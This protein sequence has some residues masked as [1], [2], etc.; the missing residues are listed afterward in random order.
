M[1]GKVAAPKT[2]VV[3]TEPQR[4][5]ENINEHS[6]IVDDQGILQRFNPGYLNLDPKRRGAVIEQGKTI[7][8]PT[9]RNREYRG[10]IRI[11]KRRQLG[12]HEFQGVTQW[13]ASGRVGSHEKIVYRGDNPEEAQQ[14]V[15]K[16]INKKLGKGY[17]II[18]PGDQPLVDADSA[19]AQAQGMLLSPPIK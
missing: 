10:V 13:G 7:I 4:P 2:T 5:A 12:G 8:C 6:S 15:N 18:N 1:R 3:E 19:R 17:Q 14:A 16:M 11:A 9:E